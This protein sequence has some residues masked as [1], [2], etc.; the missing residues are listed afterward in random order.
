MMN[1]SGCKAV[2]G[3]Q[4]TGI[5]GRWFLER[6]RKEFSPVFSDGLSS[7]DLDNVLLLT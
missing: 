1:F 3:P 4:L 5:I 2:P 7:S 6:R